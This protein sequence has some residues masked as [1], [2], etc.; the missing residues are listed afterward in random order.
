MTDV[1]FHVNVPDP[2]SYAC[3]LVRKGYLR[4]MT[5]LVVGDA[6]QTAMLNK[7]LWAL[8]SVD[9]VPHCLSNEVGLAVE[10]SAVVLSDGRAAAPARAFDVL[11]N[12]TPEMPA[13]FASFDKVFEVV[14]LA[15]AE[16]AAAR[17]RWRAY[18]QAGLEPKRH[19]IQA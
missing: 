17:Q 7:Q 2:L 5:A 9:F 3:R 19:E 8:R 10:R 6:R 4:G 18:Q 15:E 16:L 1:A 12:L 14:S 11:V 13:N